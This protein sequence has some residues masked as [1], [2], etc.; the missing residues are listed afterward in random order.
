MS[1]HVGQVQVISTFQIHN[2]ATNFSTHQ[3][4]KERMKM[5]DTHTERQCSKYK[6]N[7]FW[8]TILV[9]LPSP[10]RLPA[11]WWALFALA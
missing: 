4:S 3:Q 7:T 5:G 9:S 11:S 6:M 8:D 2:H 1:P 10:F